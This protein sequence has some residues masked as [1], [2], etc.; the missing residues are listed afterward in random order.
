MIRGARGCSGQA[1]ESYRL[2]QS[3]I[4][5]WYRMSRVTC[6]WF[7]CC[8]IAK[9]DL[10]WAWGTRKNEEFLAR[11]GVK[12]RRCQKPRP[13]KPRTGHPRGIFQGSLAARPKRVFP[14]GG[15]GG[16]C[17]LET[18]KQILEMGKAKEE[19]IPPAASRPG[20]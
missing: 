20:C 11:R 14:H 12:K 17:K 10:N 18:R 4:A 13:P 8:G 6:K 7:G 15:G 3:I 2:N 16:N 9:I 19:H 5:Y 1:E